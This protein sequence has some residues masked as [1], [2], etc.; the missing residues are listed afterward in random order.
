MIQCLK[1]DFMVIK[2]D[3]LKGTSK[4]LVF[5]RKTEF[6]TILE[7]AYQKIYGIGDLRLYRK[8]KNR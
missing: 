4:H 8:S 3:F 6:L 7:K 5:M 1:V 2:V